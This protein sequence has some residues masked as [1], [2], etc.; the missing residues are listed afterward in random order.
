[1]IITTKDIIDAICTNVD[2]FTVGQLVLKSVNDVVTASDLKE[3]SKNGN[4]DVKLFVND[5]EL[6]VEM[7]VKKLEKRFNDASNIEG[8]KLSHEILEQYKN[9]Y[10]SKNSPNLKIDKLKR[11]IDKL[12]NYIVNLQRSIDNLQNELK[13]K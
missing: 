13:D 5:I 12:G 6:D 1:M 7:F 4:Y 9:D 2:H 11:Q 8:A 3:S 10:D